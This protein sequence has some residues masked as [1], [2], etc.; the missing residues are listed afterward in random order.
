MS[1][2]KIIAHSPQNIANSL[3]TLFK[4][5]FSIFSL[6][7]LDAITWLYFHRDFAMLILFQFREKSVALF[8]AKNNTTSRW[9]NSL[10]SHAPRVHKSDAILHA[11]RDWLSPHWSNSWI[12][13]KKYQRSECLCALPFLFNFHWRMNDIANVLHIRYIIMDNTVMDVS[14][15]YTSPILR[16]SHKKEEKY[17]LNAIQV[18]HRF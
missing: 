12:R 6:R 5:A 1:H 11:M 9:F 15:K 13:C 14:H 2:F 17:Y 16:H 10:Y 8:I 4:M 3:Y 18:Y 7:S